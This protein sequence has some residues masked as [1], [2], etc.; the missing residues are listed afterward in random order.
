MSVEKEP[1]KPNQ[2]FNCSHC[3]NT[4][5]EIDM[6]GVRRCLECNYAQDKIIQERKPNKNDYHA[7]CI[8]HDNECIDEQLKHGCTVD[9]FICHNC[10]DLWSNDEYARVMIESNRIAARILGIPLENVRNKWDL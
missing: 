4:T 2:P 8:V 6:A 1:R 9:L 10:R 3:G 7:G 5:C